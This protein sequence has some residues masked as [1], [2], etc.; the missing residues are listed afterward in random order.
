MADEYLVYNGEP[1]QFG[2]YIFEG[3]LI[4]VY[5][6]GKQWYQELLSEK[7]RPKIITPETSRNFMPFKQN[8]L[9]QQLNLDQSENTQ[10]EDPPS[11]MDN[12][13]LLVQKT[14]GR[15]VSP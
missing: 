13:A 2:I 3:E 15:V 11:A 9:E 1:L 12:A 10:K 8:E 7:A 4:S 6:S 5:E 14:G